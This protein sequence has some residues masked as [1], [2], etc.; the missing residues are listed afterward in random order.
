M[1]VLDPSASVSVLK[2]CGIGPRTAQLLEK[3][4]IQTLEDVLLYYPR[5]WQ[6]RRFLTPIRD[7]KPGQELALQGKIKTVSINET[8]G[9]Y[10]IVTVMLQDSSGEI[11]CRW[12]RKRSYKYDVLAGFKKE[13]QTNAQ[14]SVYGTVSADFAGKIMDAEDHEIVPPDQKESIHFG[15]IAPVYPLTKG[16]QGKFIR[17]LVHRTL[18]ECA[19]VDPLPADLVRSAKLMPVNESLR[20]LH[21]PATETEKETARKRLAFQELFA[22][23]VVL[24]LARN[25][26]RVL[27]A[28]RY[29]IRK[30]LLTPFKTKCGFEFTR[31]QKKVINEIFTD[32]TSDFPMNRLLQGD[33]GSGKTVVA[34]SAMLL[35]CENQFQSALMSPT[36]ILAEQHFIT[37]KNVLNGLPVRLGLLTG[38]VK[39]KARKELLSDCAEGKVDIVVGTHALIEE[40]VKFKNLSL[41][42]IDEQHRFG[43]RHRLALTQPTAS[44]DKVTP[45]DVLVMT[46][47]PIPRTLSLGLY[48]D[49]D[50]STIDELPPGRKSVRTTLST[51]QDAYALIRREVSKKRQA[52]VVFPLVDESDK[53]ELKAA[54]REFERLKKDFFPDISVGLLHGQLNSAQKEK[55]MKDF[56]AGEYSILAATTVIEVGIDV[57]NATVMVVQNADRFGLATLHQLRGRVGRGKE[58][59]YCVLVADPRTDGAK[60]RLRVLTE[61]SDGFSIAETDLKLR[62]PGEIF[63]TSQ[64]GLPPLRIA[65]FSKDLPLIIQSRDEARKWVEKDP[66]LQ[67]SDNAP[68]REHIRRKFAQK[69]QWANIA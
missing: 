45:P 66:L 56:C 57:P 47:T 49:L 14:L 3:V 28:D 25:K 43:V 41:A 36:E 22:I 67:Q 1:P 65:D 33:V 58:D 20:K 11:V 4:G 30:N 8:R 44:A 61:S 19:L 42:V 46:A 52:Y 9:G 13:F 12:T 68:L 7:A 26:R 64:H 48:G 63:G 51:E 15:R 35:A 16:L 27:R 17:R 37:L 2:G 21:F 23:Q 38:S 69:W 32:L 31:S 6:D 62:G 24:A 55:A 29:Q 54:I 39:G 60:E 50:V 53:V 40:D 5:D 18:D 59:S 34:I 10:A